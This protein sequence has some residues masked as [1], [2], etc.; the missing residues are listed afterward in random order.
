MCADETAILANLGGRR[1]NAGERGEGLGQTPL[2]A[3][4]DDDRAVGLI[5]QRPV[6][7]ADDGVGI[8]RVVDA[9][10]AHDHPAR[11]EPQGEAAHRGEDE[12]D[13]LLVVLDIGRF[14]HDFR[15]QD[16]V[17]LRVEIDQGGEIVGQLVAQHEAERAAGRRA[18][19]GHGDFVP[20]CV[21]R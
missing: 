9:H 3:L 17:T 4:R 7:F 20:P 21:R 15:H 10:V 16:D 5:A 8:V 1:R 18:S 6:Q 11:L 12:G 2:A 13:L 14:L 19:L